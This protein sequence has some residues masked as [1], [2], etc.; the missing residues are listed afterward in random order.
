MESLTD[1]FGKRVA[2]PW[3]KRKACMHQFGAGSATSPA[4]CAEHRP[5]ARQADHEGGLPWAP[6]PERCG[7]V[8]REEKSIGCGGPTQS[9]PPIQLRAF[10]CT[11]A[12]SYEPGPVIPATLRGRPL[13]PRRSLGHPS[14][15]KLPVG[16]EVTT[17][18]EPFK[19]PRSFRNNRVLPFRS[20]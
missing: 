8:H 2:I 10:C 3:N 18:G 5:M 14:F 16:N 4:P 6:C 17:P 15:R 19:R 7:T 11:K 13:C 12:G 20:Q 9:I 1:K